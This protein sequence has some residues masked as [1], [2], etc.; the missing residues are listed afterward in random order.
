MQKQILNIDCLEYMKTCKNAEFDLAIV[1]PPYFEGPNQPDYYNNRS[2]S[3]LPW[4]NKKWNQPKKWSVPGLEY[5]EE[6]KRVSRN[7]I[8][9]GINYYP[10]FISL[11][12]PGRL[13]WDK[14]NDVS[15]F[16]KAEIASASMISSV[17]IFRFL[18]MGFIREN[19]A[20]KENKIHPTQKPVALYE[21]VL[22]N[23][24]NPS[25]RIL[26]T[27][28][29]SGSSAIAAINRGFD[30]VGCELD[31]HYYKKALERISEFE[32]QGNLFSEE[33]RQDKGSRETAYNKPQPKMAEQM[34]LLESATSG[35]P[36]G[37]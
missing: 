1:D 15:T 2:G 25:E 11:V 16:S 10:A 31:E 36:N 27:H 30:F 14:K 4:K 35:E 3:S 13:I 18:W 23:Y 12:G 21:W 33:A 6:L 28:L 26:D 29:G 19:A 9:W 7:Q 17:Q 20:A 32:A 34:N 5:F 8:I 24:S 22:D 37:E